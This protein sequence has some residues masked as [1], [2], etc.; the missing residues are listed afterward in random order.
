VGSV[1]MQRSRSGSL[2]PW[3]CGTD[4]GA[5]GESSG[6]SDARRCRSG[7]VKPCPTRNGQARV[8]GEGGRIERGR[9]STSGCWW[10]RVGQQWSRSIRMKAMCPQWPR[11]TGSLR[12]GCGH[13]G[14]RASNTAARSAIERDTNRRQ[15]HALEN[16]P[17]DP[18]ARKARARAGTA[19][20][21]DIARHN[22]CRGPGPVVERSGPMQVGERLTSAKETPPNDRARSGEGWCVLG[23]I[24][25]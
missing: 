21:P 22:Q 13:G 20:Q 2:V 4:V 6:S 14:K 3:Q 25:I 19:V 8:V 18:G 16:G 1:G 10:V 7:V 5:M 12:G 23:C 17:D 11:T 15:W 24:C 9:W